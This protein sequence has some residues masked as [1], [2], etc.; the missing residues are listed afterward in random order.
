MPTDSKSPHRSQ[1]VST[2]KLLG[3]RI[4]S[5]GHDQ[6]S[7]DSGND[8][9]ITPSRRKPS[10]AGSSSAQA[11]RSPSTENRNRSSSIFSRINGSANASHSPIRTVKSTVAIQN[12]MAHST[13]P[14]V[15]EAAVRD[16]QPADD[17]DHNYD[18]NDDDED[19]DENVL[20]E[21]GSGG[22]SDSESDN[23]D[24]GDTVTQVIS[25]KTSGSA[26]DL[27]GSEGPADANGDDEHRHHH[28]H[29][30]HHHL[31]LI[32]I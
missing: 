20:E 10:G 4:L 16:G 18:G 32:H 29:H 8:N 27:S 14:F 31:S 17:S 12:L 3:Q 6:A 21:F 9:G 23:D 22:E 2:L 5:K 7:V 26:S 11:H 30:H 13:N 19:D 24:D 1:S 28:H 25:M 15:K